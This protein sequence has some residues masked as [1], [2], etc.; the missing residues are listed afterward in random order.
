MDGWTC[1]PLKS[2]HNIEYGE[3]LG[4]RFPH[5]D[6]LM[7]KTR[8]IWIFL[9][10]MSFV[11]C[12]RKTVVVADRCGRFR[13]RKDDSDDDNDE[14]DDG[15]WPREQGVVSCYMIQYVALR[16]N[17]CVSGKRGLILYSK[18]ERTVVDVA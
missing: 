6:L 9:T 11:W 4:Q 7:S 10:T 15:V 16:I 5:F 18:H 17:T 1:Q 12:G 13:G 2:H 8:P 3:L 14:A